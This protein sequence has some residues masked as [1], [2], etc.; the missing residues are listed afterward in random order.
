MCP[1]ASTAPVKSSFWI[2]SRLFDIDDSS[3]MQVFSLIVHET[4]SAKPSSKQRE[5]RPSSCRS[6]QRET[7]LS[8]SPIRATRGRCCHP[9]DPSIARGGRTSDSFAPA[10]PVPVST[11]RSAPFLTPPRKPPESHRMA[12]TQNRNRRR[13][14]PAVRDPSIRS[15]CSL[16]QDDT[17]KK[18][19]S[20]FWLR[21]DFLAN[22]A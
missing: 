8:S 10:K 6:E 4:T 11:S 3:R 15:R 22:P 14:R 2:S 18:R 16:R 1:S 9:D 13:L 19:A 21:K 5:A 17:Q 7:D 20:S 12:A